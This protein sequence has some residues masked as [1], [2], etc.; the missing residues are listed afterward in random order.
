M[1]GGGGVAPMEDLGRDRRDGVVPRRGGIVGLQGPRGKPIVQETVVGGRRGLFCVQI[2]LGVVTERVRDRRQR[3]PTGTAPLA[4][5][6]AVHACVFVLGGA[7]DVPG[8]GASRFVATGM[9][10][11]VY[12]R[13]LGRVERRRRM[14]RIRTGLRVETDLSL[15]GIDAWAPLQRGLGTSFGIRR[16]EPTVE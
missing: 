4:G 3:V 10:P 13:W 14:A 8:G 15:R 12:R 11:H 16:G 2:K 6:A 9:R 5:H 7:G 1:A